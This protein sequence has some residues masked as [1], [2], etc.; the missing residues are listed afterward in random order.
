MSLSIFIH[1][2]TFYERV[3][4]SKRIAFSAKVVTLMILLFE[5]ICAKLQKVIKM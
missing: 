4:G 1:I 5:I 3:F 2:Y